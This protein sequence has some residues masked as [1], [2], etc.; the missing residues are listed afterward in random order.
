MDGS[1]PIKNYGQW[2]GLLI[3]GKATNNLTYAA[4]GPYNPSSPSG[5][6]LAVADGLG[7]FEGFAIQ[8]PRLYW[9]ADLTGATTGGTAE[10]F[11]DNDNSGILRYVSVRFAGAVLSV[12]AE[13]NGIS[14]GSVG[15]GTTV[16]HVEVI[17][18]ADDN[19]EFF[20]G[21]VNVK[22]AVFMFGNDDMFDYDLD[23]KGK[24]QFIFSIKSSTN[25]TIITAKDAD[26]GFECDADDNKSNLTPRSHPV[27]YNCTMIGNGKQILTSDNSGIAGIE[28]KELTEGEFYNNIFANF[29]YGFNVVKSLGTRAGSEEAWHNWSTSSGSPNSGSLKVKC[30][31]FIGCQKDI[32]IDKNA[33]GVA[34]NAD[35]T[36]FF[37]TDMNVHASSIPGFT[38][39][40]AM[41]GTTNA[42]GT[43]FDPTPNP[44]LSKAGCPTPPTDGFFENV[45][46]KGA[47]DPSGKNWMSNWAYGQLLNATGGLVPCPTDL[48]GDGFTDNSDFL[49]LLGQFNTAC[50]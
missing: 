38:Y 16:E 46:Y 28:A 27:I 7:I 41:D 13:I 33:G 6:R 21:T 14:W 2:G 17:S 12:G 31:T 18:A 3:A 40:W 43:Q 15:R 45:N 8:D 24:A 39:V 10:A 50:Q 4:N 47:F 20:G 36:Q 48:N 11:D 35:S 23:Y 9:G 44:G 29:R 5:G 49:I 22:H 25:D 34:T 30:N 26:N 42:V 32:A 37:T 1:F 19:M